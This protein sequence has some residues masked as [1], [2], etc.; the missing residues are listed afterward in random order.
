[1]GMKRCFYHKLSVFLTVEVCVSL[2]EWSKITT[3]QR[4]LEK[5]KVII[6]HENKE[7]QIGKAWGLH[8]EGRNTEAIREFQQVLTSAPESVDAHYGLGLALRANGQYDAAEET[9][10]QALSLTKNRQEGVKKPIEKQNDELM[11]SEADRFMMLN[12]MITQRLDELK[13][14]K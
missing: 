9:F 4:K 1:M 11:Y 5:E 10:R 6:M 3:H 7:A 14:R 13:L 8:R 12:R 2:V